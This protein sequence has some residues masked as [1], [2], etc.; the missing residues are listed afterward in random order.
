[1]V[2]AAVLNNQLFISQECFQNFVSHKNIEKIFEF[3]FKIL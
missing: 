1:M 2:L 3:Y